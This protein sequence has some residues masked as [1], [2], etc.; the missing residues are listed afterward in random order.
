[1]LDALN[2]DKVCFIIYKAR[3]LR[4]AVEP[5]E[6][7]SNAADDSF[8]SALTTANDRPVRAELR[9]FLQALDQDESTEL[10]ALCWLGRGDFAKE[11]WAETMQAAEE[12]EGPAAPDY[13]MQID[14]LA[15]YLEE[16]LASFDLN[17]DAFE[18]REFR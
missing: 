11:E 1:M 9:A 10:V 17:C 12:R 14:L 3:E 8:V 15:E 6:S 7:G 2:A 4:G 5:P 16:G 13:L 18:Q